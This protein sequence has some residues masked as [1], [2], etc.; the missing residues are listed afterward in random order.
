MLF[1]GCKMPKSITQP[2]MARCVHPLALLLIVGSTACVVPP[3]LAL[4]EP[5]A[6]LN[7]V[8]AIVSVRLADGKELIAPPGVVDLQVGADSATVTGYDSDLGDTLYVQVFVDYDPAKSTPARSHCTAPPSLTKAA[9]RTATCP[10][11]AVCG[12]D[13]TTTNPHTLEVEIYDREPQIDGTPVFRT[14][15]PPGKSTERPYILN[16]LAATAAR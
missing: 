6:G 9:E 3:P 2:P 4:D 13:D 14:V 7:G 16:C 10:M 15:P 1:T 8:P 11:V 5:D 12:A